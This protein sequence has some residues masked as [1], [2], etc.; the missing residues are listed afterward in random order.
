MFQFY[1]NMIG[2]INRG[3]RS[4]SDRD[5]GPWLFAPLPLRRREALVC[6]AYSN[7]RYYG[8]HVAKL[9][10]GRNTFASRHCNQLAYTSQQKSVREFIRRV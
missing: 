3:T 8:R 9:Y 5:S 2:G 6:P 1:W 7:G 10:D 4:I